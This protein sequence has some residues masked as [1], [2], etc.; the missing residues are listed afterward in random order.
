VIAIGRRAAYGNAST[1]SYIIALGYYSLYSITS[2]SYNTAIGNNAGYTLET[3]QSNVM[4]GDNSNYSN[5]S[6]SYNV[7]VGRGALQYNT[8]DNN[9]AVGYQ[10][11]NLLT[12]GTNNVI[13]GY[14]ADVASATNSN[15]IVIGAG[16]TSTANNQTFIGNS[17]TGS[18]II[19][20]IYGNTNST[21]ALVR[22]GSDGT[23]Y[24]DNG[25]APFRNIKEEIFTS[26]TGQTDFILTNP[27]ISEDGTW[28]FIDAAYS[29][30]DQY[31][32]ST[33]TLSLSSGLAGG[34][35]VVIKYIY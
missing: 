30:T 6:G 7:A 15:S 10:A 13:L 17:S 24:Q 12:T 21:E 9:V 32:L 31:T 14:D 3:G 25:S 29:A 19:K 4:L 23:L 28:V 34:E 11:G 27:P 35:K 8:T 22:V 16:A 33:N 20:G 5:I 1:A 18:T 2:G 26:S